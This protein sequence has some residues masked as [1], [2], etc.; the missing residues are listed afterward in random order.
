MANVRPH[1]GSLAPYQ[2]YP[3]RELLR[4]SATRLPEKVAVI[5]GDRRFTY[6]ELDGYSDRFAAALASGGVAKGDR[7]GLLA[8]NCVEFLVA[9]YGII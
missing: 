9:F 7:V 3:M 6:R 5:D 1:R 2:A 4:R 8:P